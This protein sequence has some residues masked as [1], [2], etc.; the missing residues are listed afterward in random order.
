MKSRPPRYATKLHEASTEPNASS[1]QVDTLIN[2]RRGELKRIFRHCGVPE[3]DI[4]NRVEDILA[5]R[6]RWSA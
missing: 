6:R 3:I 2:I 1:D 5:E 4:L